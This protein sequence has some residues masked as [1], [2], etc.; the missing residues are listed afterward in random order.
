M[1]KLTVDG[2]E[3]TVEHVAALNQEALLKV[4]YSAALEKFRRV[5]R[6]KKELILLPS[7]HPI[8]RILHPPCWHWI[9]DS[10]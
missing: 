9:R 10:M 4:D 8:L 6:L 7:S 5:S 3:V 1:P 2:V